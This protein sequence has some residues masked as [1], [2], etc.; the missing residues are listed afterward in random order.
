MSKTSTTKVYKM[1]PMH[2]TEFIGEMTNKLVISQ[3]GHST[4]FQNNIKLS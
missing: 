2:Y 3:K 1:N 4:F